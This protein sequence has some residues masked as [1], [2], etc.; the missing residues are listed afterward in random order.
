MIVPFRASE[1]K[2]LWTTV[3]MNPFDV[4]GI[5]NIKTNIITTGKPLDLN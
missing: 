5:S 3:G 4:E 1:V 2:A